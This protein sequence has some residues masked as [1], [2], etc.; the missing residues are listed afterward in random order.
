M[1]IGLELLMCLGMGSIIA[2]RFVSCLARA[3]VRGPVIDAIIM[4]VRI[5]IRML[6]KM[7]RRARP[8]CDFNNTYTF[9]D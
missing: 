9:D 6:L 4:F 2:V 8:S 3:S 1:G 5:A 7:G